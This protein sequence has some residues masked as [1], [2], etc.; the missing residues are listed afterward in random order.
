MEKVNKRIMCVFIFMGI[1]ATILL[2]GILTIERSTYIG[3]VVN[4]DI[5][6]NDD[7]S[8]NY[9]ILHFEDG[10]DLDIFLPQQSTDFTVHSQIIIEIRKNPEWLF[11]QEH[12]TVTKIIK[13]PDGE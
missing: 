4:T 7:G 11:P 2:A 13:V 9:M 12:Y 10:T 3:K 5:I 6:L 1:M 8:V